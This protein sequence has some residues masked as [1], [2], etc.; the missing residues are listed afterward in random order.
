MQK[1]VE[2]TVLAGAVTA[3]EPFYK[4]TC[5]YKVWTVLNA[6]E[7]RV[8]RLMINHN[9]ACLPFYSFSTELCQCTILLLNTL[10]IVLHKLSMYL[11]QCD[12]CPQTTLEEKLYTKDESGLEK[13]STKEKGRGVVAT[14]VFGK[15]ELLCEYSGELI[16]HAEAL[17][18]ER[19]YEK[20]PRI[21]CYLYFFQHKQSKLW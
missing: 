18:R 10:C 3:K 4:L 19:T 20:D 2:G 21:G 6:P 16:S 8:M 9:A 13:F 15:G 14:K 12:I 1:L 11:A 5:I 7:I 17:K